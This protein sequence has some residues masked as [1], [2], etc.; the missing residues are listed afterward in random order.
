MKTFIDEN[1]EEKIIGKINITP[2]TDMFL[3]LLLIF[4]IATPFLMQEGI[5]VNLPSSEVS[6]EQPEGIIV[7]LTKDN[8]IFIENE[9]I[10]VENLSDALI[11]KIGEAKEK[12][13]IVRGDTAVMLGSAV[14]IMDMAKLA[15]ATKIA[16][17]TEEIKEEDEAKRKE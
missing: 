7:T 10:A 1:I 11:K 14:N 15:G 17:A 9:E 2:F 3:I 5:K 6:Q 4:M 12:L 13:V 8:K 16:I